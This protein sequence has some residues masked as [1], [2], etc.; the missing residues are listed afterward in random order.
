MIRSRKHGFFII[1]VPKTGTVSLHNALSDYNDIDKD[2]PRHLGARRA[3]RL[4]PE[5]WRN[6]RTYA[7]IR[8]PYSWLTSYYNFLNDQEEKGCLLYTSP[9]PR[10]GL[11]SRMPSS[12]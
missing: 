9:S 11:L 1:E 3:R 2:L 10:D 8:E 12:A 4:M 5:D 7:V 6:L